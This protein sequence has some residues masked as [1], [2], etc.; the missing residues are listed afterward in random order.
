MSDR[1][2]FEGE[3]AVVI[4]KGGKNIS[5]EEAMQSMQD[6]LVITMYLLGI[7][8]DIQVSSFQEK[9]FQKQAVADHF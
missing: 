7:T 6:I 1:V 5:T 3:L 2:D 9:T 4:G 8:R